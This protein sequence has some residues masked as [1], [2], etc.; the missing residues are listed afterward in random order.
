[1]R[2]LAIRGSNLAS[3]AGPFEV[4]FTTEPL[5]DSG[6]FAISGPTGSGKSTLLDALCLAL[7]HDTPRLLFA[8]ERGVTVPDVGEQ[9]TTPSDPRNLLR[10]GCG[11]GHAEVDFMGIGGNRYRARWEVKRARGKS[12]ARLQAVAVSLQDMDSGTTL[13]TQVGETATAIVERVGLTFDQF[14]RAV[15]L[16]QND[17]ATLLK[18]KQDE[19]ASLLEA[20][21]ST[22]VFSVV[23]R[24]AH[25]RCAQERADVECL[26]AEAGA[27]RLLT[28]EE[29]AELQSA[30]E[31]QQAERAR[32]EADLHG[33]EVEQRWHAERERRTRELNTEVAVH[34]RLVDERESRR[35]ADNEL[36]AWA[37]L[38]PLLGDWADR[39]ELTGRIDRMQ[40]DI[41]ALNAR[42]STL[43]EDVET[44]RS[45]LET[46]Q[47]TLQETEE[48]RR[49]A[50]PRI[51]RARQLDQSIALQSNERER[52]ERA[53]SETEETRTQIEQAKVDVQDERAVHLEHV[54][55]WS[56]WQSG[57]PALAG[58]A[59]SSWP[60]VGAWLRSLEEDIRAAGD[61]REA[62]DEQA[63]ELQDLRTRQSG[64][65]QEAEAAQTALVAARKAD[66]QA[67]QELTSQ[68]PEELDRAQ[69]TH[70]ER[71]R[72]A[73]RLSQRVEAQARVERALAVARESIPQLKQEQTDAGAELEKAE[74]AMDT[75]R[76]RRDAAQ[77]ALDKARLVADAHTQ[78]LRDTLVEGEA[79][80]VC[81]SQTHPGVSTMDEP[82]SALLGQLDAGV[83]DSQAE[84]DEANQRLAHLVARMVELQRR[85]DEALRLQ[86]DEEDN[87]EQARAEVLDVAEALGL[88]LSA[89]GTLRAADAEEELERLRGDLHRSQDELA[90]RARQVEAAKQAADTAR[91]TLDAC[92]QDMERVQEEQGDLRQAIEPM[93]SAARERTTRLQSL[94]ER[95]DTLGRQ[96]LEAG[97]VLPVDQDARDALRSTWG[98]GESIR[99]DAEAARVPLATTEANLAQRED[100]LRAVDERIRHLG[101]VLSEVDDRLRLI[102]LEREEAL[103]ARDAEAFALSLDHA[104]AE[105]LAHRDECQSLHQKVV[106]DQ[107][108]CGRELGTLLERGRGWEE[109]RTRAQTSLERM[110]ADM[111]ASGDSAPP[112]DTL[113]ETLAGIPD[114]V[115]TRQEHLSEREESL[116]QAALRVEAAQR[117]LAD[118][119]REAGSSRAAEDAA[120]ARGEVSTALE[121]VRQDLAL[122]TATKDQDVANR[123]RFEEKVRQVE[124]LEG[125]ANKWLRLDA[126][127]G[128]AD[129]SKFKKYAQ[130]FTLEILLEYANQHLDSFAPRY[131]L[132]R[133]NEPLSLLIIDRDFGEE[134]RTVHSLSGGESFLVSLGLALALATLSSERVRVESL[135]I[136]EGFGSLDADTLNLV[137]EALDRLQ[138][139]GRRVGVISHVHDM[140]E[141]IGTQI[142]VEP[143]GR[144]RSR[145]VTVR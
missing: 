95:V 89:D 137:M 84:L 105:A 121:S 3:L 33:I 31:S 79:C 56:V 48:G 57:N 16:A 4:D 97:A 14:R 1:M 127:I 87:L 44:A 92:V 34:G 43:L 128:Q 47:S 27:V 91:E 52:V 51:Q 140:A 68:Q 122:K 15:L 36:R 144:G 54:E 93:E 138:S 58:V 136:D 120:V 76:N 134:T 10:R 71:A 17:F 139:Q 7:Y 115:P 29:L 142:R 141:R 66:A 38:L 88:R 123:Q 25:E 118:H 67:R 18:A 19:R 65:A 55:A 41:A 125:A 2:I 103:E 63:G 85:L 131:Q 20:L 23:S 117:R 82:L 102:R 110:M 126:L 114:D 60:S 74:Q 99:H 62:G 37:R 40:D 116:R 28:P 22:E 106:V 143:T 49:A 101:L 96:C 119:D 111:A 21:T 75:A 24:L 42:T 108:Q 109:Q 133:G 53:K 70:Q 61:L 80:P 12:D 45:R 94:E 46:A 77:A 132:R 145:V 104:L 32:L 112:L 5:R 9:S 73:D 83:R 129:G 50:Q 30:L 100:Q 6:L 107:S 124:A 35:D 11:E 39:N 59:D 98:E 86:E 13:A 90:Q 64:L 130:Q 113:D 81:G 69:R 78:Q 72:L 135:F 26:R 8:G